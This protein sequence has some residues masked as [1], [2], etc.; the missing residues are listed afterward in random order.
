[1]LSVAFIPQQENGMKT[2]AQLAARYLSLIASSPGSVL[3]QTSRFDAENYRSYLFVHP[4]RTLAASDTVFDEIEEALA[5]GAF[6]AGYFA[7]E[8]GEEL[9]GMGLGGLRNASPP[10][11][12]FGVYDRAFVFDHRTG[13]FEG[14]SPGGVLADG[15]LAE[16]AQ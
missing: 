1:M 7:Y 16:D 5:E 10:L 14:E 4:V 11:A 2:Y 13:E 6:V 9:K 12:W 3:L 15:L 8:C